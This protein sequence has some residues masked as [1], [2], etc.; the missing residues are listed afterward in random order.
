MG[1]GSDQKCNSPLLMA[2]HHPIIAIRM[3]EAMTNDILIMCFHLT[4]GTP[5]YFLLAIGITILPIGAGI[6]IPRH[7][8]QK[9]LAS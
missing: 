5:L 9:T 7:G 8:Y 2:Y 1:H 3:E 4:D 6:Y